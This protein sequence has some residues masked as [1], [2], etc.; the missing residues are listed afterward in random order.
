[1]KYQSP[2]FSLPVC[3]KRISDLEYDLRVGKIT[4]AEYDRSLGL[5]PAVFPL[6][7]FHAL[8]CPKCERYKMRPQT[9]S[10]MPVYRCTNPACRHWMSA[11]EAELFIGMKMVR[12]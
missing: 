1:M 2:A 5:V 12:E 3:S 9:L 10:G 11:L 4:Q 7:K 8:A 6:P